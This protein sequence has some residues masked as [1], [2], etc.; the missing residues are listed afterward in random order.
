MENPPT[1]HSPEI[2]SAIRFICIYE[3]NHG[4]IFT[5]LWEMVVSTNVNMKI[6]AAK[7][8]KAIVPYIDAKVASTHV[9]PALITLGSDQNLNVKLLTKY[10]FK[11]M[12]FLRMAKELLN[13]LSEDVIKWIGWN[14][15]L[16]QNDPVSHDLRDAQDGLES[17]SVSHIRDRWQSNQ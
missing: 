5:I 13:S 2:I 6:N 8:L 14:I 17:E 3:E 7:L 1:K 9:L 16:T 11:W 4:L 10:G 12:L 15:S